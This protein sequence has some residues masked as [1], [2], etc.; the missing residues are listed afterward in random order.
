MGFARDRHANTLVS[1]RT[2]MDVVSIAHTD[3]ETPLAWC[4]KYL[5]ELPSKN[6]TL[7]FAVLLTDGCVDGER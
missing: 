6:G 7:P 3:I 1:V 5:N 4:I 2:A